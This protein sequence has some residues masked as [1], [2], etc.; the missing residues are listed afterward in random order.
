M[1]LVVK[2]TGRVEHIGYKLLDRIM[3]G[4]GV[5]D[6]IALSTAL[7][8]VSHKYRHSAFGQGRII[9]IGSWVKGD[10]IMCM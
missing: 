7:F 6:E 4:D 3:I 8:M 1:L 10:E 2:R 5:L 9:L